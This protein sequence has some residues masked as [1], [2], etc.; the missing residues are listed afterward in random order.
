MLQK[1]ARPSLLPLMRCVGKVGNGQIITLLLILSTFS[2]VASQKKLWIWVIIPLTL[3]MKNV[4]NIF[5]LYFKAITN[6]RFMVVGNRGR[7]TMSNG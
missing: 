4:V 6:M 7:G 5:R 1:I 3:N 2:R